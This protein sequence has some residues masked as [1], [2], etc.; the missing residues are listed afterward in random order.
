MTD[1]NKATGNAGKLIIRDHGSTVEFLIS[2]TDGATTVGSV[3]WSG[4]INGTNVGGTVSLPAGFGTKSV[5]SWVAYGSQT[6]TFHM[7]ATGTQGLG[8]PTDHSAAITRGTV[9]PAPGV[10]VASEVDTDSAKL[11][12]GKVPDMNPA[13]TNYGVYVS[14]KSDFSTHVYQGWES[15]RLTK[16]V[17]GLKP[18]TKYYTRARA[19]NNLGTGP[20][21]ATT[22]FTTLSSVYVSDGAAW[23][24]AELH[25]SDGVAWKAGIPHLSDGVAWKPA[26]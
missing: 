8:G 21:C 6:V 20:Y 5:G 9:P 24:M 22:N 1:Y 14:E 25:L 13:V 10:V 16:T 19:Q 23:A 2:C 15:T 18:G 12:W 26:G 4:R 3:G 11:T 7:N 17:T